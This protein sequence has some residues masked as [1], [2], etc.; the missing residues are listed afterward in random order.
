MS[1]PFSAE[2][3]TNHLQ[4]RLMS[5]DVSWADRSGQ[6]TN[7]VALAGS[8]PGQLMTCQQLRGRLRINWKRERDAQKEIQARAASVMGW[9]VGTGTR[10][11]LADAMRTGGACA[12]VR[13][14]T[15]T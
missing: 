8:F 5:V 10:D 15:S 14:L 12:W 11:S 2:S 4:M 13:L 7:P 3:S 1:L 6:G 9:W